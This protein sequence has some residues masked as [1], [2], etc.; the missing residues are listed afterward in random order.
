MEG[1]ASLEE[2]ET[3]WHINDVLDANELLDLKAEVERKA[4]EKVRRK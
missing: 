1:L 3:F 4:A 2:I